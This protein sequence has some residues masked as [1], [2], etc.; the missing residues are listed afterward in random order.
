MSTTTSNMS[1]ECFDQLKLDYIEAIPRIDE[2][3]TE[4]TILNKEQKKR[5]SEIQT[6]MQENDIT[7]IDL[8]GITFL[9]EEKT[10]VSINFANLGEIIENPADLEAFKQ[11]HT[12]T[13][14]R[15]KITRPKKRNRND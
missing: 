5:S 12:K 13:K 2:L 10:S 4:L 9:R 11:A 6:Y 7:E 3:K 1:D 15:L 14:E 8:S